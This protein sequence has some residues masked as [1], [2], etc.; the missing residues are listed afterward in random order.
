[1]SGH[2]HGWGDIDPIPPVGAVTTH[3]HGSW[4]LLGRGVRALEKFFICN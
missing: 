3:T 4:Y 2:Y 1:M